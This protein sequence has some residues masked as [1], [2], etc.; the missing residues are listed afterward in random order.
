MTT[1]EK[2]LRELDAWIAENVMGFTWQ[3]LNRHDKINYLLPPP[4]GRFTYDPD[5]K[6]T[7]ESCAPNYTTD[8]A[9]A[10][11]VL[12]KCCEKPNSRS[13]EIFRNAIHYQT[14]IIEDG[15]A[16]DALEGFEYLQVEA[17]TIELAICLFSKKI[18]SK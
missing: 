3:K 4:T 2:N 12:K 9:A 10:M 1:T 13:P 7:N 6:N 15:E 16:G 18:F 17:E 5:P 14:W 11:E 8:P